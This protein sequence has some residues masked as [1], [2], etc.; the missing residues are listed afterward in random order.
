MFIVGTT[1]K[2]GPKTRAAATRLLLADLQ[3]PG[4]A[5]LFI[6]DSSAELAA[7]RSCGVTGLRQPTSR[8]PETHCP[9]NGLRFSGS[10]DWH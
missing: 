1:L 9:L 5:V 3:L 6:S 2:L 10:G 7:A 8:Q 4:A